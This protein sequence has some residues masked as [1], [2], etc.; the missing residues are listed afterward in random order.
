MDAESG[1]NDSYYFTGL[2]L[3]SFQEYTYY[4]TEHLS[5]DQIDLKLT[6]NFT[7][8]QGGLKRDTIKPL[9]C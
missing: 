4:V 5:Y 2:Q 7:E 8:L 1:G 3:I 9:Q 6:G